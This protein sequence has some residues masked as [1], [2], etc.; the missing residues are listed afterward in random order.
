MSARRGKI[1]TPLALV[2]RQGRNRKQDA[3]LAAYALTELAALLDA[4]ARNDREAGR[5]PSLVVAV[6]HEAG[7]R[8][9][10]VG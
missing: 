4:Y 1:L 7:W 9:A 5:N 10:D 3:K 6:K 2:W 8:A